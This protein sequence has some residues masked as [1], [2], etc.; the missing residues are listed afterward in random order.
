M[1][2][3]GLSRQLAAGVTTVRDLGDRRY[4]VVEKRDAG[5]DR[6]RPTIL[7]SGPPITS[8]RGHCWNMGGEATGVEGLEAAVS[9]RVERGVDVVKIMASGGIFTPGT[10]VRSLNSPSE[11][12]RLVVGEAHAAGIP[13]TAHAHALAAVEQALAAGVDGIEH[14]SCMTSTGAGP[15][16]ELVDRL[17][18]AGSRCARRSGSSLRSPPPPVRRD[19]DPARHDS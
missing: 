7:A 9:E 1:I 17:A 8:V 16:P 18:A 10:D 19:H 3:V 11:E 14:C 6:P 12:L 5:A 4:A 15:P 2:E 13:M